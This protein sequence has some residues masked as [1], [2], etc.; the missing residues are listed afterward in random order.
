MC[1]HLLGK[2]LKREKENKNLK[3]GNTTSAHKQQF[4]KPKTLEV[5]KDKWVS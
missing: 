3:L 4:E 2:N 1:R 5:L